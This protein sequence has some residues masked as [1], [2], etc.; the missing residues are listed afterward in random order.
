MAKFAKESGI[1]SLYYI[2]PTIWAWKENRIHKIKAYVDEMYT[3]LPFEAR[4]YE[5]FD[6]EVNSG[7]T[8][9]TLV[10]VTVMSL[11]TV[12]IPSVKVRVIEYEFLDS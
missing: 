9:F 7:A 1:L 8:S 10:T 3:I 5:K 12:S 4:F 11:V 6:S 2:S